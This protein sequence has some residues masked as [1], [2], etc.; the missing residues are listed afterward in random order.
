MLSDREREALVEI[1]HRLLADDPKWFMTFDATG[2][3]ALRQRVFE[4]IFQ[5]VAFVTSVALAMLMVAAHAPGPAL[6]FATVAGLLAWLIR[7]LHRGRK[8]V[9]SRRTGDRDGTDSGRSQV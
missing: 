9:G 6:F 7:G 5:V 8:A 2:R 4:S 1:E 3:E